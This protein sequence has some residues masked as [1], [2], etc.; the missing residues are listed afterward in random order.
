VTRIHFFRLEKRDSLFLPLITRLVHQAIESRLDVLVLAENEQQANHFHQR[1][2]PLW[3]CCLGPAPQSNA[4]VNCCW[5]DDPGHHKGCLLN[6]RPKTPF[7]FGRFDRLAE[8]VWEDPQLVGHKRQNY[9]LFRHCGYPLR[10]ENLTTG[11]DIDRVS[12]QTTIEGP[13]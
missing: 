8:F 2:D 11:S 7:W 6:L 9:R 3:G 1:F 12:L 13:L 5:Q 10:Y 4:L